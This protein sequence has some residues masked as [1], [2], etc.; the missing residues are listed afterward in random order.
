MNLI[1]EGLAAPVIADVPAGGQSSQY[2]TSVRR[3]PGPSPAR[4]REPET[5]QAAAV[6]LQSLRLRHVPAPDI[7][8][9]GRRVIPYALV[10]PDQE[11]DDQLAE[12]RGLAALRRWIPLVP[13]ADKLGDSDPALRPALA[14]ALRAVADKTA[15]GIVAVSR[16]A[17]SPHDL[18]YERVLDQIHR[19][20]GFL[21]LVRAEA[22]L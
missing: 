2:T 16:T 19:A 9:H 17:I 14:R 6:R 4:L 1:Q 3:P 10:R 7:A 11:T 18:E 15:E 12:A 5:R 8:G 20:G 13:E 21:G 22:E